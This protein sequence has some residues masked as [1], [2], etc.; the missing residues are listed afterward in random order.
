MTSY[1]LLTVTVFALALGLRFVPRTVSWHPLARPLSWAFGG[2]A[3]LMSVGASFT[4]ISQH[5][6]GHLKRVYFAADMKPGQ[7]IASLDEQGPQARILGPGFH[8]IPLVNLLYEVEEL[9]L[10]MIPDGSYGHLMAKDGEALADGQYMAHQ[11]HDEEFDRMLEADYFLANG[12]Q[13]GPQLSVLKPGVYRLNRYLFD[14]HVRDALNINAGEVA[15]IKSNV[16]E[17][18]NCPDSGSL[19]DMVGAQGSALSLPVVPVGCVGVWDEPLL[20]GRYYLNREAYM[21]TL[22]ST[23]AQTWIYSGGY[24]KRLV[25]LTVDDAGNIHQQERTKSIVQ[26]K[27]AADKA[28][29]VMIE[30]WRVPLDV[31]VVMQVDPNN[32]PRVVA[33]VGGVQEVEDRIVTPALRSI[34]RNVAGAPERQVLDLID[35]RETLESLVEQ[36]L[37]EEGQKAGVTIKEVRFGDPVIP[38]ALL[39]ARQRQQLADQLDHTYERERIAQQ[40]RIALEKSRAT[41]NQQ[42]ELV[43]AQIAVQIAEQER[44]QARLQGEGEKLRLT[45]ISKGQRAQTDV[46][47][48]DAVLE[49]AILGK[50][51]DAAVQNPDI[52]KVPSVY[53]QG[54]GQG[55]EGPAAILGA[56]NLLQTVAGD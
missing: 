12:G 51:L 48:R 27:N 20:P 53:V 13:K 22:I 39:V 43:H 46:L 52:V 18:E 29:I 21:P 8:V 44:E 47:G 16:Q 32:A 33:S 41:A 35:N 14:V 34:V 55:F 36:A 3:L 37:F 4:V 6:V 50:V 19:M 17:A 40:K 10:V 5:S 49:L 15:V 54:E 45:E 23:R 42:T 1:M 11:W 30:G 2:L 25:D 38:A 28:V 26:P 7:I 9:P 56:S 31:W 24:D